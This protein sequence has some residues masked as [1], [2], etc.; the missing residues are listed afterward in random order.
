MADIQRYKKK[1]K[2]TFSELRFASWFAVVV[3]SSSSLFLILVGVP[4]IATGVTSASR[5]RSGAFSGVLGAASGRI[6]V[7][8]VTIVIV[9]A[10]RVGG[11][12]A[13]SQA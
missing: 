8:V 6:G 12:R 9:A 7:V 10:L 11:A 13:R 3:F 5:R 2:L 1:A 4:M